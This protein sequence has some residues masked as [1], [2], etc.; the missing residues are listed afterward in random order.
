MFRISLGSIPPLI[1]RSCFKRFLRE[2]FVE[3]R[4]QDV[5]FSLDE[6][7]SN[8]TLFTNTLKQRFS[9]SPPSVL[10]KGV[11]KRS[12]HCSL[13]FL[14]GKSYLVLRCHGTITVFVEVD[15]V[16]KDFQAL[17]RCHGKTPFTYLDLSE[18]TTMTS[19]TLRARYTV[20]LTE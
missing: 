12:W 14:V 20:S 5:F 6:V 1:R 7:T 13:I 4:C 3:S 16:R 17:Y 19:L 9:L 18:D 8:Y 10:H 2:Q 15:S 11:I